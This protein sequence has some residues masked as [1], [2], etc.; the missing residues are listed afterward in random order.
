MENEKLLKQLFDA[1]L[2]VLNDSGAGALSSETQKA[3]S[4]AY[5]KGREVF[6][7]VSKG[8]PDG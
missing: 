7:L 2:L 5:E 8:D 1:I 4:D 3:V 6:P